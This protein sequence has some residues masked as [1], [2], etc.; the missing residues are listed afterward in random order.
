[1]QYYSL[2]NIVVRKPLNDI[3]LLLFSVKTNR[4]LFFLSLSEIVSLFLIGR[5]YC[6]YQSAISRGTNLSYPTHVFSISL[7][8]LNF[9]FLTCHRIPSSH[10]IQCLFFSR[11]IIGKTSDFDAL[12]RFIILGLCYPWRLRP[13][14]TPFFC[15]KHNT[16][17]GHS[18]NTFF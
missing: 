10:V 15:L 5:S 7:S 9:D 18:Q 1:M 16:I 6:L 14:S 2:G 11:I 12:K 17:F 8:T 3:V 13:K 4:Q